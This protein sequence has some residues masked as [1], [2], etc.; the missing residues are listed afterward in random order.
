[1][2]LAAAKARLVDEVD[3]RADLLLDAV[4]P[5]PRPPR[6]GLRGGLRPR[7]AHRDRSRTRAWPSSGTPTASTPP[8]SARAGTDGPDHRG[9][10]ASTTRCPGIGHA[11]GHNIIATAGLGAGLAAAALA[12]E[13]G[14][15]VVILGTPAEEGGGGKVKMIERGAFDGVDA[16]LMVHPAGGDLRGHER[17]RHPAALGRPTT[18]RPPTPP[19]SRTRAAT[20]S[21]PRCSAT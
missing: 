13:L 3:E 9:A 16:A 10:A 19:P 5:H 12:D 4:A 21:T 7:P 14:G 2:D 17:H 1:M 15:R 11:C 20:R 8:S 6:A 18:G